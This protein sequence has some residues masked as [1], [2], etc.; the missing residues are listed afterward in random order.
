[1]KELS[2]P[3]LK[4]LQL[5]RIGPKFGWQLEEWYDDECNFRSAEYLQ[6]TA[7]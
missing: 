1:M 7:L 6:Y 3:E 5:E 4:R 2:C